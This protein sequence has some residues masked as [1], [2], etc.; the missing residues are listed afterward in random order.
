[1]KPSPAKCLALVLMAAFA[2]RLTAGWCWQ[3]WLDRNHRGPFCFGD[4]EGYWVLARAIAHGGPY[5]YGPQRFRVF[6]TP[7]YPILVAPVF[8]L[9]ENDPSVAWGRGLSALLDTAAVAAVGW[10]AWR[11]FSPWAGVLAAAMAA[12]YP[13]SIAVGFLI[14]SEAPFG[15]LM[16]LHLGL[17]M[18]AW[19]ACATAAGSP[20]KRGPAPGSARRLSP[21]VLAAGAGLAAGAATLVRPDWLLFIPFATV[22]GVLFGRPRLRHLWLG[23]AMLVGLAIV[24]SPWWL[25][26]ARVTGRFVPTTLQVGAS[27]Y[28]GWNPKATGASDWTSVEPVAEEMRSQIVAAD[29][30]AALSGDWE[31]QLDARLRGEAIAWALSNP[32]RAAELAAIKLARM[33]NPW[34]NEPS[35]SAWPIR[36]GLA[37]VYVPILALGVWG[38]AETIRRGW[39]YILCWLPAVYFTLLHTVFVSSIRYRQPAMLGLMVL[40]AGAIG[41][42]RP[43]RGMKDEG[44]R[45]NAE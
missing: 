1:M 19:N 9:G 14:L 45:M 40:A 23:G 33:W 44:R 42:W 24:M 3:G 16:L 28:D 37:L 10:L 2:L 8:L 12:V 41:R 5:Q 22:V 15:P 30:S 43:R 26:N 25:R 4:S 36:W 21:F 11:L 17:W 27:L 6:R 18:A 32:G 39:P 34:P 20:D 35:M 13:G 29:P 31:Y 7:G 38:A